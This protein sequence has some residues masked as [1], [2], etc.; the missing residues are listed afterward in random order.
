MTNEKQNTNRFKGSV[1][2][3]EYSVLFGFAKSYKTESGAWKMKFN[4]FRIFAFLVSTT[5]VMWL[6]LATAIFFFF[7]YKRNYEEMTFGKALTFPFER[8]AF[9]VAMGDYNINLAISLFEKAST[10]P[11][12]DF[13]TAYQNLRDGVTRSPKNIKGKLY[14]TRLQWRMGNKDEAIAILEKS[15]PIGY[16]NLDYIRDYTKMLIMKLDDEKLIKTA[17]TILEANPSSQEVKVYLAMT[18]AT[19]YAMHGHYDKSKHYLATYG[20]DKTTA[21]ILRLSKNE[22]EQGNREEAISIISRNID[23]MR[24]L[25]P[26]Y[27]LLSNYYIMM[28]DYDMVRKYASLRIIEKPLNVAPKIDYIRAMTKNGE[29]E[30]AKIELDKLFELNKDS[31]PD[32][33]MVAHY[34]TETANLELMR[35]IYDNAI[36]KDF[37]VSQ[38]CMMLLETFISRGSYTDA[39]NFSEAIINESPKWLQKNDD[40]F[41][42]LRAAAYYA[43]GNTNMANVLIDEVMKR[44]TINPRNTVATARRFAMLGEP[45]IAQKLYL[46]AVEKDPRHQYALVRL[47]QFEI[48]S[49]NSTDLNKYIKRLI[50]LRRPPRDMILKARDALMSDRFI[51]TAELDSVVAQIDAIFELEK[52][53][54]DRIFSDLPSDYESEQVLSTF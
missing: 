41:V 23:S 1:E 19:V 7:K 26:V 25:D 15:L 10:D 54:S 33:L 34:A 28:N 39:I 11:K 40:V 18:L 53:S 31:E 35:K 27:A 16:N 48:D 42:C 36:K 21:G 5:F 52:A 38:F 51:F 13:K 4:F 44:K 45:K 29:E 17:T 37:N 20:L 32:T 3:K 22:W 46:T 8:Q 14:F 30:K 50:G 49:G 9:T 2:K 43:A 12:F 47:I 24:D 6:M